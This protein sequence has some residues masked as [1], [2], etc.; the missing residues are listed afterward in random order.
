[1]PETCGPDLAPRG[2]FIEIK[3]VSSRAEQENIYKIFKIMLENVNEETF[4]VAQI[5]QQEGHLYNNR[6]VCD[7]HETFFERHGKVLSG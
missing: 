3:G 5:K 2:V 4:K 7:N 6:R 1:M